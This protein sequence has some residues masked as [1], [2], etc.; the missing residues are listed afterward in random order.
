MGKKSSPPPPDYTGAAQQ[1]AEGNLKNLNAQT[2]ANRANQFTPWGSL[3]WDRQVTKNPVTGEDEVSWTSY[4][5][6]APELQQALQDELAISGERTG[7]ARSLLGRVG[8]SYGQGFDMSQLPDIKSIDPSKF[9]EWSRLTADPGFGAVQEVQDAMMSRMSPDLQRA[10]E[11]EV[12][13]LKSQG[14]TEGSMAFDKAMER[15]DRAETDA[16]QQ[17]LLGAAQEYGNIFNRSAQA[18][19]MA[20]ALRQAQM[21][22]ATNLM[23]ASGAERTRAMQ[24]QAFLRNLPLNEL[25]ALLGGGQVQNPQ[26]ENYNT[27]GYVGGP[28]FAGAANQQYQA[29]LAQSNAQNAGRAGLTSGIFGLAGSMMGGPAGGFMGGLLGKAL[30][31]GGG[32]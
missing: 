19:N 27:A 30:S 16:R 14:I 23:G 25:N 13:R 22:E 32:Q 10:R 15:L 28:D 1:T 18:T 2:L 3:I 7:I 8:E 5:D 24:E 21:G 31:G 11:G 29:A 26:F 20:N 12:Q 17:A 6:V 4:E 9:D